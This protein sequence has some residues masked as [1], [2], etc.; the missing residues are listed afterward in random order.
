MFESFGL[1]FYVRL[2][3]INYAL[4]VQ[5]GRRSSAFACHAVDGFDTIG[6]SVH[7]F[8]HVC[9]GGIGDEFVLELYSVG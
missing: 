1:C 5:H 3:C 9:D 6:Q 2:C 7:H 8:V 4:E